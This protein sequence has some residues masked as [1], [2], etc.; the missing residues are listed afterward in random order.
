[1]CQ[2]HTAKSAVEPDI[3]PLESA[4]SSPLAAMA[5]LSQLSLYSHLWNSHLWR[6]HDEPEPDREFPAGL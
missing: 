3:V 4:F 1:M 2:G 5:W 6:T